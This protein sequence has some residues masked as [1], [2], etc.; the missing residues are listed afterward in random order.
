MDD[1]DYFRFLLSLL[2]V[3][4]LI[5]L[6]GFLLRRLGFGGIRAKVRA[7]RNRRLSIQEVAPVDARRKLV[8]VRRDDTEHLILIGATTELLIESGIQATEEDEPEI[9]RPVTGETSPFKRMV[10][11]VR[12]KP[13]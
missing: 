9:P 2:L 1:L 12:K 11:A 13:Q 3:I 10:D 6:F 7:G 5:G 8:L 4:G